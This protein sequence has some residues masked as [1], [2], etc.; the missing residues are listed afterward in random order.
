VT[1]RVQVLAGANERTDDFSGFPF[2]AVGAAQA[3]RAA[4]A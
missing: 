4:P 3:C 1:Q 2:T